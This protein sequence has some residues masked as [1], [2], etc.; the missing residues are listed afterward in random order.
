M[1]PATLSWLLSFSSWPYSLLGSC[2][3]TTH[4][5][6]AL[7]NMAKPAAANPLPPFDGHVWSEARGSE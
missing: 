2:S 1:E 6:I 5:D 4:E 7:R 3:T